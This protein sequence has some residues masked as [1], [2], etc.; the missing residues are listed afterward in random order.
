MTTALSPR[1]ARLR[2][3]EKLALPAEAHSTKTAWIHLDCQTVVLANQVSG[4][5]PTGRIEM[6]KRDFDALVDWY[7][8]EQKVNPQ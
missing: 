1:R 6:T 5:P 8:R 2:D 3:L 4:Q 7:V